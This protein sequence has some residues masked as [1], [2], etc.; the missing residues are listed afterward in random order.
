MSACEN[1][2]AD[3]MTRKLLKAAPLSKDLVQSMGQALSALPAQQLA[4]LSDQ[5]VRDT[6]QVLAKV[7]RFEARQS[8]VLV[9]KFFKA[10]GKLTSSTDLLGLD[11]LIGGVSSKHLQDMGSE[12]LL[13]AAKGGLEEHAD[14]MTALQKETIVM[15]I[16]ENE[17]TSA[18]FMSLTPSLRKELPTS[19]IAKAN[20]TDLEQ[21]KGTEWNK[22]QALLL[23]D[24]LLKNETIP[25]DELG[26][27][28]SLVGGL[29]CE[30]LEQY[31]GSS[32]VNMTR[33]LGNVTAWL[34]RSQFVCVAEQLTSAL[35]AYD[36]QALQDHVDTILDLVPS[37]ILLYLS[38]QYICQT[39]AR[40]CARYLEKMAG[41]PFELLPRSSLIREC[42][43]D[44]AIGCLNKPVSELSQEDLSVLGGIVCEFTGH[45]VSELQDSTFGASVSQFG[46]CAQFHATAPTVLAAKITTSL[47][48]ASMWTIETITSLGPMISFLDGDTLQQ[49]PN[50]VDVN[51]ALSQ[52]QASQ[53]IVGPAASPEFQTGFNL[54]VITV[55]IFTRLV[56]PAAEGNT[57]RRRRAASCTV[58][59][60]SDEIYQLGQGNSEWSVEQLSCMSTETFNYSVSVLGSVLGFSSQ[61]RSALIGKAIE[62]WGAPSTFSQ[63]E[64]ASLQYLLSALPVTD[65]KSMDLSSLDNL[66]SI[67]HC[68]SWTQDQVMP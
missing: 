26:Q 67:A 58:T 66:D 44:T 14:K 4:S 31:A 61:Q 50:T 48:N 35:D 34:S 59:P 39:F 64:I 20:I 12:E 21:V 52:L 56:E 5:D 51:Q 40:S 28:G 23:C 1:T 25:A 29:T 9:T 36:P 16:L 47:G 49:L 32:A 54:T 55:T 10:G 19:C 53:G 45:N 8:R 22:G 41:A 37:E 2:N 63:S 17:D 60:T 30:M 65:L 24:V 68:P 6:I 46:K 57:Q 3:Q 42:V 15:T 13:Q 43:R 62:A 27:L 11:N 7:E 38:E 33:G 18:V